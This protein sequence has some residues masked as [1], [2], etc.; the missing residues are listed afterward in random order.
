M[1][2]ALPGIFYHCKLHYSVWPSCQ[3]FPGCLLAWGLW[4]S[5]F[6]VS[7]SHCLMEG[8]L[9]S[10]GRVR[11]GIKGGEKEGQAL[12]FGS[13]EKPGSFLLSIY[14]LQPVT[15]VPLEDVL[16]PV[17]GLNKPRFSLVFGLWGFVYSPALFLYPLCS[18]P[19]SCLSFSHLLHPQA[20]FSCSLLFP[21]L[22]SLRLLS[23]KLNHFPTS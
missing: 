18:C 10:H 3:A 14:S 8:K 23:Q 20:Y 9:L 19:S 15:Q 22:L 2:Q 16:F 13:P 12:L 21:A 7:L 5:L 11:A 1:R 6:S 4:F 17:S